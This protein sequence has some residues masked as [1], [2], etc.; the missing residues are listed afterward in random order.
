MGWGVPGAPVAR[1]VRPALL[2]LRYISIVIRHQYPG[3]KGI[4]RLDDAHAERVEL[5]GRVSAQERITGGA[6]RLL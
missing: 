2:R 1:K 3:S 6:E 4:E 5:S